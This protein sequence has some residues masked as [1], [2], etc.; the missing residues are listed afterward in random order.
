MIFIEIS[1]F[2]DLLTTPPGMTGMKFDISSSGTNESDDTNFD[3][4][5]CKFTLIFP[6]NYIILLLSIIVCTHL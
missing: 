6:S 3:L 2:V 1:C 4:K 5:V